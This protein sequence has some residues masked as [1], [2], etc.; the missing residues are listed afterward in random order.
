LVTL[1][2]RELD[3]IVGGLPQSAIKHHPQW[4]HGERSHTLAWR[5]AGF[6]LDSADLGRSV[7][8]RRM[9]TVTSTP[10]GIQA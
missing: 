2:W 10:G 1:S 6:Q 7:T 9:G 4:W 3:E 8:F 5:R